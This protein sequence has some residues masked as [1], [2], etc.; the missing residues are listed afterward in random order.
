MEIGYSQSDT[1]LLK[2]F[3]YCSNLLIDDNDF[4]NTINKVLASTGEAA[5]VD[6]VYIFKNKYV[7]GECNSFHYTYEWSKKGVSVQIDNEVLMEI[8]WDAFG[9]LKNTLIE[10][11]LY[12]RNVSEI[13]EEHFRVAL[14]EQDIKSI[15]FVPI[16]H[17]RFFWGFI[18][19]DDCTHEREWSELEI[20]L[21]TSISANIGIY[22][23]RHE[24]QNEL[25]EQQKFFESIL[26]NIPGDIAVFDNTARYMFINK[27]AVSDDETR[28]WLIG[29]TDFDY[30]TKKNI[31]FEKAEKRMHTFD[32]V[33]NERKEVS[34]EETYADGTTKI[35]NY[36]PVINKKTNELDYV[37]GYSLD[38]THIK[39]KDEIIYN[40]IAAI[41]NSTDGVALLKDGCYYY[42]NKAH[43]GNFGYDNPSELYGKS[44]HT[45]YEQIEIDRLSAVAFPILGATGHW[46][47]PTMG[48]SKEGS[49]VPQEISLTT[50]PNGELLCVCRDMAERLKHEEEIRRLAMVAQKS[51]TMVMLCNKAMEVEWVNDAFTNVTGYTLAE[52]TGK[53]PEEFLHGPETDIQTLAQAR[54]CLEQGKSCNYE[55]LDYTKQKEKY[56]VYVDVTPYFN[57]EHEL[58]GYIIVKTDIT[59]KKQAEEEMKSALEQERKLGELKTKF[60][61][62]ASHEF[63]TPLAGIQISA[64]IIQ[65]L[66]EKIN[67][68]DSSIKPK[69]DK[70]VSRI[71]SE[72]FRMTEIMN[73][74]LLMGKIDAGRVQFKPEKSNMVNFLRHIVRD[75]FS[76]MP[77]GRTVITHVK[78]KPVDSFFDVAL[79]EHIMKNLLSNAFKYSDGKP[80]PEVTL[81]YDANQ[82]LIDV[83]D[84]GIGIPEHEQNMIF[85]SFFRGSN[86]DTIQGTGLGMVIIKQFIE[87]HGGTITFSSTLNK[88]SVFTLTMPVVNEI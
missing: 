80:N 5:D 79:M 82:I 40:Q 21:L 78:G 68:I 73:N 54:T 19:F 7:D 20:A 56:W 76:K 61:N 23:K 50:L 27:S 16:F 60:V 6:R 24:L 75:S 25:Q 84:F 72:I 63:R 43:A 37:I 69:L 55:I 77:N 4:E 29:K 59:P 38:I 14:E 53:K 12:Y 64:D 15:V 45:I 42:M 39:Q 41:E 71:S 17:N 36:F 34:F 49:K 35:R 18:G 83:K 31:T 46:T 52:V 67:I 9:D 51:K 48:K 8:P 3:Q 62:L 33:V 87:L 81:T 28:S 57:S 88:G 47:G 13:E 2:A 74:V 85:Q 10:E 66:V 58:G 44:W 86:T 32:R 70:H 26:H 30:C 11:R 1:K 65:M 22:L